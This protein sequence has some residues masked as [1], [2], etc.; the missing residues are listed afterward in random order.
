MPDLGSYLDGW[1]PA[2]RTVRDPLPPG[3]AAALAALLDLAEPRPAG[4]DPLPP[5]WH[6]LYFLHWPPQREL[7]ADGHPSAGDFLPPIPD[8]SRMFAGGR[9][10]LAGALRLGQGAERTSTLA[11][12]VVKQGRTGELL[13]VTV[14]HELRQDGEVRVVDE[15]DLVYRSGVRAGSAPRPGG[16]PPHPFQPASRMPWRSPFEADST[17]LFRFSALTA[18]AHRI[19]YDAPYAREVEGYPGIVVH[20]PLLA[21]LMLELPRRHRPA[22]RIAEVGYRLRRPV[23]AGQPVLVAGLPDDRGARLG[24]VAADGGLCAEAE[25]TLW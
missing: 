14:R 24:V 10:R 17:V 21:I 6:W 20:G 5:L 15:Q 9:L 11:G 13:F 12:A 1:E 7:G 4:G 16:Q 19:H 18:N 2:P 22:A 8:R 25:V 23:V 3:P